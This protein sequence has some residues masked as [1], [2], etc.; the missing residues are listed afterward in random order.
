MGGSRVPIP[1]H[2]VRPA[3]QSIPKLSTAVG[4]GLGSTEP[5]GMWEL[6][7]R[8]SHRLRRRSEH[9]PHPVLELRADRT[10]PMAWFG[11]GRLLDG[12]QV[13]PRA[14]DARRPAVRQNTCGPQTKKG[15]KAHATRV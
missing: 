2:F 12:L 13:A 4:V 3:F 5:G 7:G 10:G 8:A 11:R 6:L 15:E 1:T 14:A 9:P